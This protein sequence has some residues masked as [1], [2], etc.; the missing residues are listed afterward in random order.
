MKSKKLNW[1]SLLFW[2]Y[3]VF[4]IVGICSNA[5]LRPVG[6]SIWR[7][8]NGQYDVADA[9]ANIDSSLTDELTYHDFML[10]LNGL[11]ENLLGTRVI[12]KDDAKIVKSDSGSLI[13]VEDEIDEST[14]LSTAGL[15]NVY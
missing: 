7:L 13:T 11:R 2:F 6:G 12:L 5:V 8:I 15:I 1:N 14:I 4:L 3:L 10:E 9:K